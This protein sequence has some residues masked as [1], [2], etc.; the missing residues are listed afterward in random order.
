MQTIKQTATTWQALAHTVHSSQQ[1]LANQQPAAQSEVS[2]LV[3]Q[4]LADM[5]HSTVAIPFTTAAG[6]VHGTDALIVQESTA[7]AALCAVSGCP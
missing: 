4:K 2:G 5:Q 1:H 7:P 3:G 6:L